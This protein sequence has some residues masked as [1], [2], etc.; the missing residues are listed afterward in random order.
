MAT[1][2]GKK[3][4]GK[5]TPIDQE[6]IRG[7]MERVY[8][9]V[10][11]AA[12]GAGTAAKESFFGPGKPIEPSAQVAAHGRQWDFPYNVNAL[13]G[14][15][16]SEQSDNAID[17]LT[18]RRLADPALGGF[19]LLRL[20]IETR[21]DQMASQAWK[22]APRDKSYGDG[23]ER[24]RSI[25][26]ALR[27]PDGVNSYRSWQRMLLEDSLVIDA[28]AVFL[29]KTKLKPSLP[30]LKAPLPNTPPEQAAPGAAGEATQQ[31]PPPGDREAALRDGQRGT[32]P[33]AEQAGGPLQPEDAGKKP[34]PFA[35]KPKPGEQPPPGDEAQAQAGQRQPQPGERPWP[36][37]PGAPPAQPGAEERPQPPTEQEQAQAEAEQAHHA[38]STDD[39][40]PVAPGKKKRPPPFGRA[41]EAE[42]TRAYDPDQPRDETGKWVG[43][44]P[45][46]EAE[47]TSGKKG[48]TAAAEFHASEAKRLEESA[49]GATYADD[50]RAA[51]KIHHK[52]ALAHENAARLADG[53][54]YADQ[55]NRNRI[56]EQSA[57]ARKQS[58]QANAF[59]ANLLARM[60]A[61]GMAG[62]AAEAEF[63]RGDKPGHE[64]HGNQWTDGMGSGA[65]NAADVEAAEDSLRS[66]IGESAWSEMDPE[67]RGRAIGQRAWRYVQAEHR[68][69]KRE[70][71]PEGEHA[72]EESEIR[73]RYESL[74]SVM[75]R[76][77]IEGGGFTLDV[78]GD[79]P[80]EGYAVGVMPSHSGQIPKAE[81]TPGKIKAW[82]DT[83]RPRTL[84][85][86]RIRVGGWVDDNGTVWLDIV[87]VYAPDER[88]HAIRVGRR[89]NQIGI[90]DLGALARGDKKHAFI[91][92]GGTGAAKA[93]AP[94]ARGKATR[95]VLFPGDVTAEEILAELLPEQYGPKTEQ[96][97]AEGGL[98]YREFV[99]EGIVFKVGDTFALPPTLI[100]SE[101]DPLAGDTAFEFMQ[102]T[103]MRDGAVAGRFRVAKVRSE[104][105]VTIVSVEPDD[106]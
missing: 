32:E 35:P 94:A 12:K 55:T 25:E 15:P 3:A 76:K 99:N 11:A 75:Q 53:M 79:T 66:E 105:T 23:G 61:E 17:F 5:E 90:M 59:H 81:V 51:A 37:E 28:A 101:V 73:V 74:V 6:Q 13:T 34:N 77:L 63:T 24:A 80:Q 36:P 72:R 92:T 95:F 78:K 71:A 64:F 98:L 10:I 27:K 57:F 102:G 50:M 19:D 70:A 97:A 85:D 68:Q 67:E 22:I 56:A 47:R 8:G 103:V 49:E 93:D 18:L 104:G 87:R 41:D 43:E 60:Q 89:L 48:H 106:G 69:G 4:G 62:K 86:K 33:E 2:D 39:R 83:Q 84:A 30:P 1:P 88:E 7:L 100:A 54:R 40:T 82:L 14:R 96:K 9:A 16:R 58:K 21:K 26:K 31:Q 91:E 45:A 44:G 29:H 46:I 20:A 65:P 42:F 38:G 52:A